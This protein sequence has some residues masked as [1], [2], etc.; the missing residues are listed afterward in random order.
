MDS[1]HSDVQFN[2]LYDF[3]FSDNCKIGFFSFFIIF[4]M[5]LFVKH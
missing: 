4:I 3:D 1:C 2:L 5:Y